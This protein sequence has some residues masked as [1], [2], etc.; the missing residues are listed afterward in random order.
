MVSVG[1]LKCGPSSDA[2]TTAA[3]RR[4][5]D[6]PSPASSRYPSQLDEPGRRQL[7]GRRSS[8]LSFPSLALGFG[9]GGADG[10]RPDVPSLALDETRAPK[11]GEGGPSSCSTGGAKGLS[12]SDP[13]DGHQTPFRPSSHRIPP[14]RCRSPRPPTRADAREPV[15][16]RR[17]SHRTS[18]G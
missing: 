7:A 9:G 14:P 13:F 11:G 3:D 12:R 8:F 5:R 18:S 6:L 17:S 15:L 16:R 2:Q 1:G 10:R 4:G